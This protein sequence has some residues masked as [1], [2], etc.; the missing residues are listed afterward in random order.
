MELSRAFEY[1]EE[2]VE[3]SGDLIVAQER[4]SY[5]DVG[6]GLL[7]ARRGG[8]V[9]RNLTVFSVRQ[10]DKNEDLRDKSRKSQ[11]CTVP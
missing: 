2:L 8:I 3:A 10:R 11:D 6:S 7:K 9:K 1:L 4:A 5:V